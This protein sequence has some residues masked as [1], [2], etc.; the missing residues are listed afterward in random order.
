MVAAKPQRHSLAPAPHVAPVSSKGNK[1]IDSGEVVLLATAATAARL[2]GGG[3][4]IEERMAVKAVLT[5]AKQ[6]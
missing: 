6:G 5:A 3:N 2:R 1:M 4:D